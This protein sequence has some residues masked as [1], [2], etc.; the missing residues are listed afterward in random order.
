MLRWKPHHTWGASTKTSMKLKQKIGSHV[1]WNQMDWRQGWLIEKKCQHLKVPNSL[2]SG[3]PHMFRIISHKSW[4][5]WMVNFSP[6]A[7]WLQHLR[8]ESSR[9]LLEF[10]DL[11]PTWNQATKT[12]QKRSSS[13]L[14][15]WRSGPTKTKVI[16]VPGIYSVYIYIPRDG[17][18]KPPSSWPDDL[19]VE[20]KRSSLIS[21]G[22][23]GSMIRLP[24]VE[25][26]QPKQCTIKGNSLKITIYMY[27]YT[28]LHCSKKSPTGPTEQTPKKP[29]YLI[30]RSQLA[31]LWS[32]GKVPFNFWW[33][34][35]IP[36]KWA[37]EWSLSRHK[38][39]WHV[40]YTNLAVPVQKKTLPG[41]KRLK[42]LS[43]PRPCDHMI[44]HLY[45]FILYIYIYT[46]HTYV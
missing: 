15:F 5:S 33:K 44:Y 14:Y 29:E 9:K 42:I 16:W 8:Q 7:K 19:K 20:R 22:F 36:P 26:Y 6:S 35:L 30:A 41:S 32:V 27:I 40:L 28:H 34:C 12:Q 11:H 1:S 43:K 37:I 31:E 3:V 18:K 10:L 25:N 23:H 2:D 38:R 13:N 21:S 24:G 4:W 45:I 39:D 17:S 46:I